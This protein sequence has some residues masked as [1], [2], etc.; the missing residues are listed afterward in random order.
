MKNSSIKFQNPILNFEFAKG[1]NSKNAKGNSSK[2]IK[3]IFFKFSPIN[4]L[5]IIYQLSKFEAPSCDGFFEI[6]NFL[7]P[8]LKR[9]IIH[10]L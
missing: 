2:E 6:S 4:P 3:Y 1:N 10:F 9:E 5:I 8:N 7:C